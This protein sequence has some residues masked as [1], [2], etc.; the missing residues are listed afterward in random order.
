MIFVNS[1]APRR[2]AGAALNELAGEELALAHHGSHRKEAR[3]FIEERL[4][5][6][7]ARR[8]RHVVARAGHRHGRGRPGGAGRGARRRWRPGIQ[9]IGR[10]GPPGGRGVQGACSFPKHASD[11]LACRRG[12]RRACGPWSRRARS[13]P[14]DVLAQ[15]LVATV[16]MPS[17]CA[18]TSSIAWCAARRPSRSCRARVRRRARHALGTLPVRRA[19]PSCGRASPGTAHGAV[20]ARERGAAH[21]GGERRHHPR[22]WPLRRVPAGT[23]EAP[24]RASASSTRR[25]CSSRRRGEVFLLGASSVAHR[26]D[27]ARPRAR[28]AR[29]GRA[30][31]DAVLEAATAPAAASMGRAHRRAD[32]RQLAASSPATPSA[33]L[34]RPARLDERAASEL[35]RYVARAARGHGRGAQRPGIVRRA[36]RRRARRPRV[37]I[38]SPFGRSGAR[39]LGH[40][41]ARAPAR[42][43]RRGRGPAHRRRHGLSLARG[44][45]S[46]PRA[47]LPEPRRRARAGRAWPR[48]DEPVRGALPRERRARALLPGAAP[49]SATA[50]VGAAQAR[51]RPARGGGALRRFPHGARDLPRVPARRVRPDP[52]ERCCATSAAR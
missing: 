48:R 52:L 38:L 5:R 8:R 7:A 6:A 27:H 19:S 25:W 45:T 26:R 13:N 30:R 44:P 23:E 41:R 20:E 10:A 18:M 4:K 3:R 49:G 29:P 12:Q 31:Q 47:V 46:R 43:G 16:A 36:L 40:G 34:A 50:A 24:T 33:A 32:A 14:L 21:R 42:R 9:R 11:L 2:A 39:P 22:S 51:A 28:G 1:R 35:V 37:V 15:Q 17:R